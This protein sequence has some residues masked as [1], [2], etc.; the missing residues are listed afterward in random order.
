MIAIVAAR[1][2]TV[3]CDCAADNSCSATLQYETVTPCIG[4]E[5]F[6]SSDWLG[7]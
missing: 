5:D 7:V 6:K 2:A 4:R 3:D 1:I